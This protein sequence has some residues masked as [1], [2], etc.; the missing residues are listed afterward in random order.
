MR[1]LDVAGWRRVV[2]RR[3]PLCPSIPLGRRRVIALLFLSSILLITLDLRGNAAHR[4][5]ARGFSLVARR[6][7]TRPPTWSSTPVVTRGTASPT[8]TICYAR[9]SACASSSPSN[10][11]PRSR[12]GRSFREYQELLAAQPADRSATRRSRRRSSVVRPSNFQYTVEINKGSDD[13]IAVGMPVINGAGLSARSPRCYPTEHRAADHRPRVQHRVQG[14]R[15]S[16]PRRTPDD[17]TTAG[18]H[19]DRPTTTTPSG[20]DRDELERPRR[21]RRRRPRPRRPSSTAQRPRRRACR[22]RRRRPPRTSRR[23]R[24]PRQHDDDDA[25]RPSSARSGLRG[26]RGRQARRRCGSSTE[27]AG[28]RRVRQGGDSS[29]PPAASTSLAPAGPPDRRGLNVVPAAGVGRSAG[30]DRAR[31]RPRPPQLRQGPAVPAPDRS[32]PTTDVEHIL[33]R[34]LLRVIPVGLVLLALQRTMFTECARSAW[35]SR[36]CSPSCAAA[37]AGAA[38]S[39]A[40]RSGSCSGSCTTSASARRSASTRSAYGLAGF[41]AG[42]VDAVAV[43]PHWWLASIFVALGAAVGETAV[44]V[45]ETLRSARTVGRP[46]TR[47]IVPV[48]AVT[49]PR[50]QPAPHPRSADGAWRPQARRGRC[51]KNDRARAHPRARR[52]STLGPWQL[53]NE[54]L[55]SAC[56]RWC[57][58]P[59]RRDRR[60]AVVPAE[61]KRESLQ[62]EVRISQRR[63]RRCCLPERGRIFDADGRIL[64]DNQRVLTVDGRLVG[65]PHADATATELFTRLSGLLK[66]PVEEIEARYSRRPRT[67]RSCR[68]R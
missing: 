41:V 65:H 22:R 58:R 55:D 56:S 27:H 37:G 19:D 45:V 51:P 25:A 49:R 44:P 32:P 3:P 47:T 36:S 21:R 14:P 20:V 5:D 8:T 46:A 63:A 57:R 66:V 9:T 23:R 68:C 35:R 24:R 6:R 67:T 33:R 26:P 48:V 17:R 16:S 34:P 12:R 1:G 39:G 11:A 28:V 42:M 59:V 15:P 54:Q 60:P 29:R 53:T 61:V 2:A 50:C 52:A 40:R 7:S 30:G 10:A 62:E 43:D 38:P 18:D 4:P 31:R 13:G 64:A